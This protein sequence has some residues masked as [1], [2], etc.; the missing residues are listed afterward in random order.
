MHPP[1]DD[2]FEKTLSLSN[3]RSVDQMKGVK[4]RFKWNG[5]GTTTFTVPIVTNERGDKESFKS[6]ILAGLISV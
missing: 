4:Q 2:P 5:K 1:H 6:P 3:I